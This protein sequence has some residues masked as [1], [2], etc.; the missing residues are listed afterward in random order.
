VGLDGLDGMSSAEAFAPEIDAL[1]AAGRRVCEFTKLA[2]DPDAG[3]KRVLAALFHVAYLVAHRMRGYDTLVMEVNPRH[4][5]YY[6]GMLGAKVLGP[7]RLNRSVNAP[8]VLL[9]IEFD[10]IATQIARLGG[11]PEQVANDRSLYPLAFS[12]KEEE[13]I[14]ARLMAVQKPASMAVN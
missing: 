10:H 7:E 1:R 4:V 9:S 12:A 8:A 14:L 2:V 13:G 11:Q 3:T 5:R 6:K